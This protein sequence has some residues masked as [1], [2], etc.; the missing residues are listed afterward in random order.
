[1]FYVHFRNIVFQRKNVKNVFQKKYQILK[2]NSGKYLWE[3]MLFNFV[4]Q[5]VVILLTREELCRVDL[6]LVVGCHV[7]VGDLEIKIKK[8]YWKWVFQR[9][10][11]VSPC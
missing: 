5:C 7:A 8:S 3:I 6:A 10:V 1:M 9:K 2:T 11:F 4:F